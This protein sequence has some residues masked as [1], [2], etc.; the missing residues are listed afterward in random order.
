MPPSTSMASSKFSTPY[1]AISF[2]IAASRAFA[3]GTWQFRQTLFAT[4]EEA[5]ELFTPALRRGLIAFAYGTWVYRFV[6]FLGIA[7]T[8]YRMFPKVV[9][10]GLALVEILFFILLPIWREMK[11]WKAMGLRQL[12]ESRR[13]Y[14]TLATVAILTV[15]SAFPFS[16]SIS[17]PAVLLPAQE[18][19]IY[20]PETAQI[21]VV[22]VKAGDQVRRGQILVELS[23][24][25]ILQKWKLAE[26]RYALVRAKLS[27]IAADKKDRADSAVLKQELQT[28]FDEIAGLRSRI[29]TLAIRA[30][31][32]GIVGDIPKGLKKDSWVGRESLLL[33]V[34]STEGAVVAG[35]V[36]ERDSGRLDTK[37]T[38]IFVPESGMGSA[39]A[40]RMSSMGMPGGKGVEF[41]YLSSTF[42]G[43]IAVAPAATGKSE[44]VSGVLPVRFVVEEGGAPTLAQRGT[45]CSSGSW[46]GAPR[47][48][49]RTSR[50]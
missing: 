11:E 30:Q 14:I 21:A 45:L 49:R 40:A 1:T 2:T 6:L 46:L 31:F 38:G 42:G 33:H 10:I 32:T 7:Y 15:L 39:I 17:I 47:R 3:L 24:R 36:N 48:S 18:A 8:V 25:D 27:R 23:S 50:T 16:R 29:A 20:P 43:A 9:G 19:W 26:F 28:I 37:S 22:H 13:S 34:R 41:T 4:R 35:L 12:F 44:P 5:P